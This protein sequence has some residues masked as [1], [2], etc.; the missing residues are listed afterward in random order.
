MSS[1]NM[2]ERR[3]GQWR[4]TAGTSLTA[5]A[6]RLGALDDAAEQISRHRKQRAAWHAWLDR[7]LVPELSEYE[8]ADPDLDLYWI[9]P[10]E[11][12]LDWG[13]TLWRVA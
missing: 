3:Y 2:I 7:N 9:P 4:I 10:S 1:F 13:G 5:L 6:R 11:S 8:V 12:E